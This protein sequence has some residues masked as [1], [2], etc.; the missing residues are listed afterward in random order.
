M[1][2]KKKEKEEK[3]KKKERGEFFQIFLI[4]MTFPK[5]AFLPGSMA[6]VLVNNEE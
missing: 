1:R 6:D 4:M 3:E 5:L 2:K